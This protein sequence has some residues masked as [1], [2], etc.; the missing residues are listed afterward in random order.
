[1]TTS[2]RRCWVSAADGRTGTCF[3]PVTWLK[4]M[5]SSLQR[6]R[7]WEGAAGWSRAEWCRWLLTS[8]VGRR[9]KTPTENLCYRRYLTTVISWSSSGPCP[10]VGLP[11]EP[12]HIVYIRKKRHNIYVC[13][14][15][16]DTGAEKSFL[17]VL[18][19]LTND[20]PEN[21]CNW[22]LHI[23]TL[24]YSSPR[25]EQIHLSILINCTMYWLLQVC[26]VIGHSINFVTN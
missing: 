18:W 15:D 13:H 5:A 17:K 3:R 20:P 24:N 25:C 21:C 2:W 10:L 16:S 9:Y 12:D 8:W 4:T 23:C 6:C 22:A 7:T 26:G 1:M 11:P 14:A 19:N